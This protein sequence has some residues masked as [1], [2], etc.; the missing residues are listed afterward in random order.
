MTHTPT[1]FLISLAA[2][3]C[4]IAD[5]AT[6]AAAFT[7]SACDCEGRVMALPCKQW[8]PII[9][10]FSTE[11]VL[12]DLGKTGYGSWYSHLYLWKYTV[13]LHFPVCLSRV[14]LLHIEPATSGTDCYSL[15]VQGRDKR[16]SNIHNY[17]HPDLHKQQVHGIHLGKSFRLP[18]FLPL[19]SRG[20]QSTEI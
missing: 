7:Q 1:C 16:H 19:K 20:L 3:T 9:I 14:A 18:S 10:H 13:F 17:G 12:L 6:A 15:G 5:C 8:E 4:W 11:M 2:C